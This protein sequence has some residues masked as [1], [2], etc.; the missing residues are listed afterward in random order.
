MDLKVEVSKAS[1]TDVI[2]TSVSW[3]D[4]Q[5]TEVTLGNV[6]AMA[7]VDELRKDPSWQGYVAAA[8]TAAVDQAV[9]KAAAGV[10][11]GLVAAEVTRQLESTGQGAVTR[12][13]AS[14]RAEAIIAT[15]V[16]TQLRAMCTPA[17]GRALSEV[18]VCSACLTAACAAGDLLCEDAQSAGLVFARPGSGPAAKRAWRRR[19]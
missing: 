18:L 8:M 1:I 12:G 4:E 14:T 16:T 17:V 10:V 15:E 7:L 11:E 2:A 19:G 13:A 5:V 6:I 9:A 3:L